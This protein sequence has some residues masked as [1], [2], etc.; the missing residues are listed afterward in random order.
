[1]NKQN[2]QKTPHTT[3]K[4]PKPLCSSEYVAEVKLHAEYM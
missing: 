1:M 2:K 3:K 4:P